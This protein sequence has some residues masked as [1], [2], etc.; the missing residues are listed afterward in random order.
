M[1]LNIDS[2]AKTVKGQKKG[3][4]TGI[5]YLAPYKLAG[6]NLCPMAEVAQCHEA[7]L[8]TA[9]RGAFTSTQTARINKTKK[10]HADK[11]LFMLQII[12]DIKALIR[13]ADRMDLTP[14]VRLNGTSDIRFENV[15]INYDGVDYPNIFSIFPTIQFYDYTKIANRKNIPINYDLTFSYSAVKSYDS[16]VK[17]AIEKKERIA[18]VFRTISAIPKMFLGLPVIS[19]DD[20]DL[21]HMDNKNCI[22]ALYAKGRAKKDYSGFVVG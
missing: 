2:N 15:K 11:N 1:Y 5:L 17:M 19:G 9:G 3:F 4:I 22:V 20:S 14:I 21:R 18:V 10:Y 12:K 8:N 7:C 6:I 16:F 13:K